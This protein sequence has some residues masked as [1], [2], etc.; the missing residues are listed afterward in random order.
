MTD[1]KFAKGFYAKPPKDGAPD[2]VK[3]SLNMKR[4]E[5]IDWLQSQTG[6]WVNTEVKI[7][8]NGNWYLE[9]KTWNPKPKQDDDKD[10]DD[11][12]PF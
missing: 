8:K 12:I 3:F 7:G 9:D 2:F 11:D 1:M 10:M 6:D 4:Q 5:A